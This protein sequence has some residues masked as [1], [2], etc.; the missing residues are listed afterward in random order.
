[1]HRYHLATASAPR[2]AEP[3]RHDIITKVMNV[4]MV[5]MQIMRSTRQT[6]NR[7]RRST[8]GP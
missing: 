8:A 3:E 4:G 2:Y 5:P 1:M 6:V 7:H